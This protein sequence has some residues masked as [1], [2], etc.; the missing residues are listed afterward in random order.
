MS[1]CGFISGLPTCDGGPIEEEIHA[2]IRLAGA[3]WLYSR[4]IE[5]ADAQPGLFV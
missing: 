2:P 1:R 4:R 3:S 5:K